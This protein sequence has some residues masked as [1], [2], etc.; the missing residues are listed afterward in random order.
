V[1]QA[2]S[3]SSLDVHGRRQDVRLIGSFARETARDAR[4]KAIE[5]TEAGVRKIEIVD[6]R[7]FSHSIAEFERLFSLEDGKGAP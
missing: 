4:A 1:E 6:A 5:L 7:S 2:F 3:V